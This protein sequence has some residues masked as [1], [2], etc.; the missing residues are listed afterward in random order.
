MDTSLLNV[1]VGFFLPLFIIIAF[2]YWTIKVPYSKRF[3]PTII[4][5]FLAILVFFVPLILA[6]LDVI[7]G[8]FGIA[9]RSIYFS[10]FLGVGILVN[11]IVAAFIKKDKESVISL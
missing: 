4:L 5:M 8:G 2:V 6:S 7:G 3:I 11:I 9:I 1:I 10:G